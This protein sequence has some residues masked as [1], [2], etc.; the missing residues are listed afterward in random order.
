MGIPLSDDVKAL[1][2]SANFAHLATLMPDGSPQSAPVWSTSRAT[3]SS[4]RPARHRSR[5]RTRGEMGA[6]HSR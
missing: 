3:V 1:I 4:S 2:R 5:P 6:W